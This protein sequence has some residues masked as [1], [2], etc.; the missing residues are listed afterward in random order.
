MSDPVLLVYCSCPDEPTAAR[1][2]EA[3]VV[4]GHAACV[5]VL[6]SVRSIYRWQGNIERSDE[7]MLI[8]KTTVHAYPV[9]EETLRT[10]H[11]YEVPEIVAVP[12]SH[13]LHA[14]LKWVRE[15]ISDA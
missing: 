4:G 13:G 15:C 9:V 7:S 1:L 12:V 8:A 14:Y 2:A 5:N 10:L 11:P 3:L 6:G